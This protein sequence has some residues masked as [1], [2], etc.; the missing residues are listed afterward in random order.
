MMF[1]VQQL[2]NAVSEVTSVSRRLFLGHLFA[3]FA[4]PAIVRAGSLMP[5]KA[6]PFRVVSDLEFELRAM[7]PGSF[8]DHIAETTGMLQAQLHAESQTFLQ[9]MNEQ[10]CR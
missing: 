5:V 9:G 3:A 10:L 8:A 6:T 7:W 1:H 4:A 2:G